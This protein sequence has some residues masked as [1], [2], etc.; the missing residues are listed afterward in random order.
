[1][2]IE[3]KL[4][5]N[6]PDEL[7][8]IAFVIDRTNEIESK[9]KEIFVSYLNIQEP[10]ASVFLSK[11]LLNNSI[12]SLGA[13]FK[14]YKSLEK[15][16]SWPKL[17]AETF[18][19]ILNLRNSFA[20]TPTNQET[21]VF[22]LNKDNQHELKERYIVLES[23][24]GSGRLEERKRSEALKEFKEAYVE[25]NKHFLKIIELLKSV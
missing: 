9:M 12:I 18:Y 24:T 17:K 19:K 23:V 25:A 3:A 7:K 15:I 22:T 10:K 20:H 14:A 6:K 13:K 8:D 4:N 5:L 16:N 1:M 21:L 2:S 11:I